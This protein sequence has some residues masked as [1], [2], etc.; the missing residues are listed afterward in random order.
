MAS[1]LI[2]DDDEGVCKA[3]SAIIEQHG[4]DPVYAKTLKEGIDVAMSDAFDIVFLDV[5]LPDGD[6]LDKIPLIAD[7]ESKPEVIIMTGNGDPDGAELAIKNGAWDYLQKPSSLKKMTL[8]FIRALEYREKKLSAGSPVA[9]NRDGIIG[10]GQKL[11]NALDELAK[12]GPSDASVS[13]IGETGTGK[14]LFAQAVHMNSPRAKRNFVVLD[15][16]SLPET[17]VASILFGHEKGAFTGAEKARE[18]LIRQADGGTL[19]LDEVGEMPLTVQKSFLRV[20]ETRRFRPI[21]D[22]NEVSS[23]FRVV[24]STH[25]DL[26]EMVRNKQ[27]RSDLLYRLRSFSIRLPPLRERGEDIK[28][29]AI[30]HINRIC[31]AYGTK[32]KGFSPDFFEA[33]PAYGWPGNVRELVNTMELSYAAAR[34]EPILFARHL[35]TDLRVKAARAAVRKM[36]P[37]TNGT[38]NH[39]S[40]PTLQQLR[41]AV[42]IETEQQYLKDL[43]IHVKGQISDACSIT[44][45][46]RSRLYD[47]LRKYNIST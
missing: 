6:G 18:G 20:L 40:F 39:G 21:G 13:I 17:L 29:L 1:V 11:R 35:P 26:D 24:S 22:K 10:T 30:Y 23:N 36:D 25:R 47:L 7:T 28:E 44:G 9:I 5:R 37:P 16:A 34:L 41:E 3:L 15:C 31:E 38:G 42:I 32:S 43:W 8:P 46:G 45:V 19:F 33:L 4:H 14:E 12:A 2:I 27:F